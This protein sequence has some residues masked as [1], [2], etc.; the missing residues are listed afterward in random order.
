MSKEK[1]QKIPYIEGLP[2][3]GL[4]MLE[5][6]GLSV[7]ECVENGFLIQVSWKEFNKRRWIVEGYKQL[8]EKWLE[9]NKDLP[10]IAL[11]C[12]EKFQEDFRAVR[13]LADTMDF[14]DYNI[15]EHCQ[16]LEEQLQL[17]PLH[18]K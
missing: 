10:F 14:P 2:A 13:E 16:N 6:E 11:W 3:I 8:K 18:Q 15:Q 17:F 9:E 5:M 4:R 1:P 7:K 12:D